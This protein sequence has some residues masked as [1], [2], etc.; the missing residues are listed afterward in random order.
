[1]AIANPKVVR[2]HPLSA[3]IGNWKNPI[4]E[5]GPKVIA[6][7]THPQ[8]MISQGIVRG[9]LGVVFCGVIRVSGARLHSRSRHRYKMNWSH[10]MVQR[11][12]MRVAGVGIIILCS[13]FMSRAAD[14]RVFT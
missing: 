12:F 6:A 4:A 5:R 2:S 13:A 11:K 9:E 8:I 3:S 1:M 14:S 10:R 7:I